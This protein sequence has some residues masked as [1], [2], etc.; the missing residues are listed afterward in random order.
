MDALKYVNLG[1]PLE[2]PE[3]HSGMEVYVAERNNICAPWTLVTIL[4]GPHPSPDEPVS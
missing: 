1:A 4:S 2:R 3:L